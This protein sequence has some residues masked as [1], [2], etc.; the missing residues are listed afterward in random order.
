[1]KPK[2]FEFSST[3]RQE[4]FR[5]SL[6]DVINLEHPLVKLAKAINW[7]RFEFEFGKHYSETRGRPAI[8]TRIMVALHYLKHAYNVSDENVVERFTENVYWQYF[9]G[10]HFLEHKPPCVP[11]ALVEWRK[12]VGE[13]GLQLM[14]QETLATAQEMGFLKAK[15]LREITV[16]TTVQEKNIA[17]PT[18]AKLLSKSRER[19][20]KAAEKKRN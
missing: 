10:F 4:L 8:P 15:E 9:C 2:D 18:D 19:L 5:T 1:M 12:R 3:P 7:S 11:T 20:V 16:D 17:F 14:L 6:V 13:N